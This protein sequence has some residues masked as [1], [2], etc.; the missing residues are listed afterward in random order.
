MKEI[1]LEQFITRFTFDYQANAEGSI[2]HP[3]AQV[4]KKIFDKHAELYPGQTM[5][6]QFFEAENGRGTFAMNPRFD[7]EEWRSHFAEE[8]VEMQKMLIEHFS[9]N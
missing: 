7:D 4:M 8:I 6:I 3:I 2:D 5:P 9:S 1:T